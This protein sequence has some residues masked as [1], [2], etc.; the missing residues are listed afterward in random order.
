MGRT[1]R[2]RKRQTST[3]SFTNLSGNP[4]HIALVKWLKSTGWSNETKL[5][6]GDFAITGR[7]VYSKINIDAS[8]PLIEL[9][10]SCLITLAT[11][12]DD[13]EF[14]NIFRESIDQLTTG[15]SCGEIAFQCLLALYLVYLRHHKKFVEYIDSIP[16]EFTTP[17]FCSKQELMVLPDVIFQEV[18]DQNSEIK[19]NYGKFASVLNDKLCSCHCGDNLSVVFNLE[20]FKWAYFVVNSRSVY[21]DDK[22]MK[23]MSSSSK[24]LK[25]LSNKPNI[26][27]APFL[28]LINH[29]DK[30]P[31]TKPQL[32]IPL[33]ALSPSS[34]PELTYQIYTN[35]NIKKNQQIFISYGTL[36]NT[37]L[38]SD[39]GFTIPNNQHDRITFTFTEM[40]DFYKAT[41]IV[42][43]NSN[44]K[45][46]FIRENRLTDEMFVNR[47]DGFSHNLMIVLTVLFV[48]V[49]HFSNLLSQVAFGDVPPFE[50][51]EQVAG[52]LIEFKR[53]QFVKNREAL[54]NLR[55]LGELTESGRFAVEYVNECICLLDDV[56]KMK[57]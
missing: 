7:G 21:I 34:K 56:N 33:S 42:Q 11:I 8:D 1:L 3:D 12:D 43:P 18:F 14:K 36:D 4:K 57:S 5:K 20:S 29:S 28:D 6:T 51:I 41:K 2:L 37:T 49:E 26:A 32:S 9:P 17:F 22:A 47:A 53:K 45:F 13:L 24:L 50:P 19:L 44:Q 54:E 55:N 40:S 30:V 48:H 10:F 27:L 46:K 15:K 52:D 25:I 35:T 39:Y 16:T 23:Q 31:E 38:L